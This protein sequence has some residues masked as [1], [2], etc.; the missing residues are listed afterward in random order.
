MKHI[1]INLG[2]ACNNR[3]RFC[4]SGH[5]SNMIDFNGVKQE[6]LN[7]AANGYNSIGFLGGE[8]TINPDILQIVK[9]ARNKGFKHIHII[10]NGRKY[11]SINF[12]IDLISQGVNRFSVSIH[13]H[14]KEIEDYL[15]QI[16]GG[17][18][19]KILGIKN[20][21]ELYN[22]GLFTNKISINIVINK[23][24][25]K[26][27]LKTLQYFKNLKI[28]DYRLNF[29]WPEGNAAEYY[30][31]LLISYTDFY[32]YIIKIIKLSQRF[33]INVVFDG[34]PYCVFPNSEQNKEYIGE[35]KDISTDVITYERNLVNRF[36]WQKRKI[37]ELKEK[38][39]LCQS[40][41][42]NDICEGIWSKYLEYKGWN[43]FKPII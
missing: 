35:L 4:M 29:M 30:K 32:P 7:S 38:R 43:E 6:I 13:S 5:I 24:N 8:V 18:E 12:L 36:N 27:I 9:L 2:R 15:T 28:E 33:K 20:L 23:K 19:E 3:C 21:V 34:I 40:C 37:N 16:N 11:K 26:D 31:D 41:L 39:K 1:E 42:Y 14:N 22:K 10:S 17:F 25:Y